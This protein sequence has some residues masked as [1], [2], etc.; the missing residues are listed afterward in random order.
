M[1]PAS[2][3]NHVYRLYGGIRFSFICEALANKKTEKYLYFT[4]I[5]FRI[6]YMILCGCVS[7]HPE[8]FSVIFPRLEFGML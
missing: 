6:F 3:L 2:G 1:A 4:C 5:G 8:Q 7:E